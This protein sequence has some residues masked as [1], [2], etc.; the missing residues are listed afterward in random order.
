MKSIS[1]GTLALG[2]VVAS[3]T[4]ADVIIRMKDTHGLDQKKPDV[5]TSSMAFSS[6]RMATDWE[7][8]G[9]QAHDRMIFRADKQ[10]LWIVNDKKKSCQQIDKATVDQ[11]AAQ[12]TAM[13]AQMQARIANMPPEQRAQAEAMM[14]K[15]GGGAQ[16][17]KISYRKVAGT[18]LIGGHLC[19]AYDSYLGDE[20][21]SHLWVAPYSAMHL[22]PGDAAVFEKMGD[23]L[24][25]MTGALGQKQRSDFIPMHELNGIPLLSQHVDRGKVT[26]EH[27]VESVT[28]GSAPAGI[29]DPP[30]GY[31]VEP[32]PVP[33][34][35][36]N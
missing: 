4:S 32:M 26:S 28:R 35:H 36:R 5:S 30:A 11:M 25:K 23:F 20:L 21:I 33:G 19:S 14:K 1:L 3:A 8:P 34:A 31:S 7:H 6:D 24:S 27:E 16:N 22:E 29:Y 18:R 12:M 9:E 10:V 13:Q 2:L 15:Y 17:V